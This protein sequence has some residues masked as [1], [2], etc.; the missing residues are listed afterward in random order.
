LYEPTFDAAPWQEIKVPGH[1]ELAWFAPPKYKRVDEGTK[2][3]RTTF[4]PP[5]SYRG[6]LVFLRFEGVLCGFGVWI[7]G[8]NIGS[9]ASSYNP[10]TFEITDSVKPESENLLAVRVTTRSKGYDLNQNDCWALS[11]IYRDVYLSS[12]PPTYLEQDYPQFLGCEFR[13]CH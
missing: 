7:N 2:L 12:I 4:H 9:C 6:R 5:E 10:A 3:Y 13:K 11:G 1:W 8:V